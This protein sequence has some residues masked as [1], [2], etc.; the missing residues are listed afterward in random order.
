VSYVE[1]IVYATA[2]DGLPLE[3]A[4]IRPT[5]REPH[6]TAILFV[7]GLTGKFYSRPVMGI[8]RELADRG[9]LF[10]TGN[11]RGHDFG[12]PYR[13]SPDAEP[14]I[15]GGGWERFDES[16]L[17]IAGW[18]GH[19]IGL[20]ARDVV[21][22]G[23]SLGALKVC[24]YQALR[25]D[26][27]V[28]ALV[29]GS[30][31][32]RAGQTKPDILAEAERMV[33]AGRGRDLLSWNTFPAGAGTHSAETYVNRARTNLDVYGHDTPNALVSRLRVPLFALFGTNEEWVGGAKELAIIRR[34]ATSAA[35]VE[36]RMF[37]GA[38]HSYLGYEEPIA[39]A[40]ADWLASLGA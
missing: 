6:P 35:S 4:A 37:D 16:P 38:D 13:R 1:E 36:T 29:A 33:V 19:V 21:L 34:N 32:L 15:Y 30:P 39:G 14:R 5:G 8:G 17:D 26:S 11:N 40:I 9:Y 12:Y 31:P 20:G 10:V 3:G 22:F 18:V 2:E 25:R 24:Y 7:H 23:H 27:R 28:R